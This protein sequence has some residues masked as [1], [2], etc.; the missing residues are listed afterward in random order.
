MFYIQVVTGNKI[1]NAAYLLKC[2]FVC[3]TTPPP[4]RIDQTSRLPPTNL[5][6]Y[7]CVSL[8]KVNKSAFKILFVAHSSINFEGKTEFPSAEHRGLSKSEVRMVSSKMGL[9]NESQE[10]KLVFPR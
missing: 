1:Q 10:S 4:E 3:I 9:L 5:K 7:R 6:S 2:L 8:S